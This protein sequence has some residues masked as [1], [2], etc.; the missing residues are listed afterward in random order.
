MWLV[1][2]PKLVLLLTK[3][4]PYWIFV[5]ASHQT[6]LD[7]CS[8]TCRGLGEGKV[9]HEPRLEPCWTMLLI[10]NVDLRSLAGHGPESESRHVC[11]II[12]KLDSKVQCYKRVTMLSVMQLADPIWLSQNRGIFCLKSASEHWQSAEKPLY[13]AEIV[14]YWL[15]LKNNVFYSFKIRKVTWYEP[16]CHTLFTERIFR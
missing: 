2:R 8:M 12:A 11:L 3:I 9:G 16:L 4:F 10:G 5:S 7:T 1:L 6:R 15:C 14:Q 13:E